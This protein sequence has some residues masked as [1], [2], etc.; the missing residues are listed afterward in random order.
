M[1]ILLIMFPL[2]KVVN[3]S[4][5]SFMKLSEGLNGNGDRAA[6]PAESP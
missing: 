1:D 5:F 3:M 6:T 2:A 4:E